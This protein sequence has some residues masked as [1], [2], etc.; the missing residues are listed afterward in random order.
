MNTTEASGYEARLSWRGEGSAHV[1]RLFVNAS[2]IQADGRWLAL[3]RTPGEE[4]DALPWCQPAGLPPCEVPRAE[5]RL[6]FKPLPGRYYPRLAFASL[7]QGARDRVPVRV[8]RVVDGVCVA[9]A[10]H[11]LAQAAPRLSLTPGT[12]A[13]APGQRLAEL[14]DGPGMQAPV[15]DLG[16][17][18]FNGDALQREDGGDDAVFYREPRLVH[19]LDAVCRAEVAALYGRFLR[20]GARVLDLMASGSSHLPAEA[21]TVFV[22]GLGMNAAELAANPRLGERVVKDLNHRSGLPWGEAQFDAVFC[23]ASIEYLL[24][25]LAVLREA[26]RVLRPGGVCVITFSD[27]WFPAK[28]IRVWREAHPFERLGLVLSLLRD[29][30]FSDLNSETVRGLARPAD[31]KYI[32]QRASADPLFA[33]WGVA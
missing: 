11:P 16:A 7:A 6:P 1:E 26:R 32:D 33:A 14:F 13:A 5:F 15:Q 20:P 29:A 31:D 28:A 8:L 21:A 10:N 9:D 19:H 24:H 23:T 18:F 30:G 2:A 27:R 25:P 22:A 3:A 17:S 4:I 12:R